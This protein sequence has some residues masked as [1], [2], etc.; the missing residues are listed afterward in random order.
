MDSEVKKE[1]G[2]RGEMKY[3]S[4]QSCDVR[5]A[6]IAPYCTQCW[7]SH[8]NTH[9]LRRINAQA[10][11]GAAGSTNEKRGTERLCSGGR[12]EGKLQE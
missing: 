5:A 9:T 12:V 4:R 6:D 8:T 2:C 1:A 3:T 7:V 11:P 10:C